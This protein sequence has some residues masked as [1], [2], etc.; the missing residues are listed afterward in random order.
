MPGLKFCSSGENKFIVWSSS[1]TI[2]VPPINGSSAYVWLSKLKEIKCRISC[3]FFTLWVL[4]LIPT[5]LTTH[6]QKVA[7]YRAPQEHQLAPNRLWHHYRLSYRKVT[8]ILSI[9]RQQAPAQSCKIPPNSHRGASAF[10]FVQMQ[11]KWVC[12]SLSPLG[13]F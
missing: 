9:I 12:T 2:S 3:P 11:G 10:V 1:P 8:L 13:C 5:I 7:L 4:F 6:L